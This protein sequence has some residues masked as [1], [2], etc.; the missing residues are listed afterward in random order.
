MPDRP[1]PVAQPPRRPRPAGA[2]APAPALIVVPP[3]GEGSAKFLPPILLVLAGTAFLSYRS[4]VADWRGP[5]RT[6]RASAAARRSKA[7]AIPIA[8]RPQAAPPEVPEPPAPPPAAAGLDPP[9]QPKPAPAPAP[10]PPDPDVMAD[11]AREAEQNK[12][13]LAELER[14]KQEAADRLEATADARRLAGRAGVRARRAKVRKVRR[15]GPS[16]SAL[17]AR[18]LRQ[19]AAAARNAQ[20][21]WSGYPPWANPFAPLGLGDG[22]GFAQGFPGDPLLAHAPNRSVA[23]AAP[24]VNRGAFAAPMNRGVPFNTPVRQVV[25]FPMP[26]QQGVPFVMPR[27]FGMPAFHGTLGAF[28]HH[29]R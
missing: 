22:N 17:M 14:V 19:K 12:A 27:G 4:T 25:P 5:W 24:P 2:T 7:A 28:G 26:F 6:P 20:D 1:V 29:A 23:T 13:K 16:E 18:L 10:G 11:I 21:G 8:A 15:R 9:P 3:E